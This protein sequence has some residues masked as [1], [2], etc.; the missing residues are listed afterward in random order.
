MANPLG[1]NSRHHTTS[2]LPDE[3]R[4]LGVDTACSMRAIPLI[5]QKLL[6]LFF[7]LGKY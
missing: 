6:I 1:W 5:N 2:G 3:P 4:F 7:E